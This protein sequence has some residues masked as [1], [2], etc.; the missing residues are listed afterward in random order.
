M[1]SVVTTSRN[2]LSELFGSYLKA[3]RR[4]HQIAYG[5]SLGIST[6]VPILMVAPNRL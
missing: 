2:C 6:G 5:F 3:L 4:E 1:I